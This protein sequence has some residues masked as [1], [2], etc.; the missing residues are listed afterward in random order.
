MQLQQAL[1]LSERIALQRPDPRVVQQ[2]MDASGNM[3]GAWSLNGCKRAAIAASNEFQDAVQW[4]LDHAED[5][6]FDA[7][8]LDEVGPVKAAVKTPSTPGLARPF[9]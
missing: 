2:L 8:L 4:A 6:D 1:Q 3:G 9:S 7:N 5:A